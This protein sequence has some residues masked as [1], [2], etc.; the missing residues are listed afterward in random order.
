MSDAPGSTIL[1]RY[2]KKEGSA[3]SDMMRYNTKPVAVRSENIVTNIKPTNGSRFSG[4]GAT[5]IIFDIPATAGGYYLDP[6]NSRFTYDLIFTDNNSNGSNLVAGNVFLDRGPQSII[7]RLTITDANNNVLEDINDY[8]QLYAMLQVL[9]TEPQTEINRG[10]LYKNCR[11]AGKYINKSCS[12][13]LLSPTTYVVGANTYVM[14]NNLGDDTTLN[15]APTAFGITSQLPDPLQGG[16]VLSMGGTDDGTTTYTGNANLRIDGLDAPFVNSVTAP[17]RLSFNLLSG[18]WGSNFPKY[19]PLSAI[20]GLRISMTLARP[21]IAFQMDRYCVTA[22]AGI[23]TLY[24][25]TS[26]PTLYL[27]WVRV[28][29]SVDRGLISS[30]RGSDGRIRIP[31][32]S[33][34]CFKTTVYPNDVVKNVVVPFS[35]S[36]LKSMYFCFCPAVPDGYQSASA[37]YTRKMLSYQAFI[38]NIAV[39]ITP[40]L[41]TPPYNEPITELLRAFH[42][43]L[44]VSTNPT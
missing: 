17:L 36:S 13:N 21:A 27:S 16:R 31:T 20:N 28:D 34:R 42:I 33:W 22:T 11:Y 12:S 1:N 5:T 43:P 29:P 30:M 26:D 24:Y 10:G 7:Q 44:N 41:V 18:I 23:P 35:V 39:P 37:M 38:G 2:D 8:Y 3:V 15:T 6:T 19:Y 32:T 40:V 25:S 4:D 14:G 9:D